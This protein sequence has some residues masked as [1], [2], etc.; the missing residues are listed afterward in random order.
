MTLSRYIRTKKWLE[1]QYDLLS[2]TSLEGEQLKKA[3]LK[4]K[5]D[6]EIERENHLREKVK[7]GSC[8]LSI[9]QL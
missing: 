2:M 8:Y 5:S 9:F 7:T 3:L 1:N 4:A 6:F